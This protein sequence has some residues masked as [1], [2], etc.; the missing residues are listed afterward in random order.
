MSGYEHL[1]ARIDSLRKEIST[2]KGKAREDLMEHLDQAVLGL[3]NIGGTAPAWA[4]EV[5]EAEH[6]DDAE[7][8]FDN[9]PL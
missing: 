2:T 8:G 5:L 9:M 4:R 7:D 6:E 3:E 1:E